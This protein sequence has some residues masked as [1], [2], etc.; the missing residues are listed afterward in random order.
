MADIIYP[1]GI[2]FFKPNDKQPEWII[3][4]FVITPDDLMAWFIDHPELAT[5]YNGK[6]Q[7]KCQLRKGKDGPYIAV[8]TWKPQA[9]NTGN[10]TAEDVK[11]DLPF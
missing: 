10:S 8:D 9:A 7:I 1:Q 11:T 5:E 2:K 6:K 3:G 4:S